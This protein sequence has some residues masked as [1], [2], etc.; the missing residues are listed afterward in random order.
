MNEASCICEFSN[1]GRGRNGIMCNYY[2]FFERYLSCSDEEFCTGSTNEEKAVESSMASS[3]LCSGTVLVWCK[4]TITTSSKFHT[5]LFENYQVNIFSLD[6]IYCGNDSKKY[7]TC[8]QCPKLKD[9]LSN[10]WCSGD[11]DYDEANNICRQSNYLILE[12]LYFRIKRH[13]IKRLIE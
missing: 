3:L 5:F 11:C 2:G 8:S 6:G 7:A 9:T 10:T 12:K 13:L 4:V 1:G